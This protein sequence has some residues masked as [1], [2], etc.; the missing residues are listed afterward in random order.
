MCGSRL[1]P[2]AGRPEAD[3]IM[4]DWIAHRGPDA[5]WIYSY[6]DDQVRP[7]SATGASII[8]LSETA[9]EPISKAGLTIIYNGELDNYK[10]L[11]ADLA[12]R[13]SSFRII[14]HRGGARGV[15]AWGPD[16]LPTLSRDALRLRCSM[17]AAGSSFL[18]RD[19]I[20]IK[21]LYLHPSPRPRGRAFASELKALVAA[22][23][24]ELR[25][26]PGDASP[27]VSSTGCRRRVRHR[28]RAG[29]PGRLRPGSDR[30]A[31]ARACEQYWLERREAATAAAAGPLGR[32]AG[33]HRGVR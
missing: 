10:A 13:A 11:R 12:A 15:A 20:G 22:C 30:T 19:P 17:S 23:G 29:C 7:A 26:E 8:D 31:A 25:I 33:G 28:R 3:D 14:G 1:L 2:A 27:S 4:N 21:P 16:V 6:E 5:T 32:P 9:N 18:A 24:S